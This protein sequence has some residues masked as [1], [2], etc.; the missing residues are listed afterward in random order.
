[1]RTFEQTHPWL[2]FGLNLIQ[3]PVSLWM[4]LGEAR[5]KCE[6]ACHVPLLPETAERLHQVYLIKG[7]VATTA[8]EGNTLSEAEVEAH[9]QGKLSLPASKQYLATEVDNVLRAVNEITTRL[10]ESDPEPL[11]PE[12]I[13]RFNGELLADLPL[14]A[15]VVP[16]AIRKHSVTV[17]RYRGAPAE[18]CEY[19]LG[20]LCEWLA[21]DWR[22]AP[23][24]SAW[25]TASALL[26]AIVAHLYLAWIHPFGD[27]NGRTARL[28]E[29]RILVAGGVPTT[30]AHLLSNHY[31]R[32]R[33]E[34][35][36]QLDQASRSGG[37]ILP[38]IEYALQGFVEELRQQLDAM[39]EQHRALL[40]KHHVEVAL[41]GP[42]SKGKQRQVELALALAAAPMPVPAASMGE[43]NPRLAIAY[44]NRSERTLARDLQDL[45]SLGL[46]AKAPTGYRA[47]TEVIS[48]M[49]PVLPSARTKQVLSRDEPLPRP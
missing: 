36:R 35:Y 6:H 8:I 1:M 38:F 24:R 18:D 34:Y 17:G 9:I 33:A 7:V 45:L 43:L 47:R 2:R 41:G 27:G 42:A 5:S 40:W 12:E 46:L 10:A 48:A 19:L 32:T 28:V 44:A 30:A 14:E 11:T 16:G 29:F 26:K 37:D 4:L 20:R 23:D 21:E 25:T 39:H 31:N 13:L 3:A 22:A 15:D 49:I